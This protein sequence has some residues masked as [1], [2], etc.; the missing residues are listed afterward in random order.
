LFQWCHHCGHFSPILGRS[1][2]LPKIEME[3]SW[4]SHEFPAGVW[5][6]QDL[7]EN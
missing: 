2:A 6:S 3:S 5:N 4:Q 1:D 7:S